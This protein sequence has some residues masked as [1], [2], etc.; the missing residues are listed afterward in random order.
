MSNWIAALL[1]VAGVWLIVRAIV[2]E[3][4]GDINAM[5]LAVVMGCLGVACIA[6]ALLWSAWRLFTFLSIVAVP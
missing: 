6:G 5:G 1:I 2:V 3:R 4:D